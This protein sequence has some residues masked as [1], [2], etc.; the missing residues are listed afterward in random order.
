[1]REWRN[2]DKAGN[3]YRTADRSDRRY[4]P[5]G[6]LL[7]SGGTHYRHD[8]DGNLVEK[9]APDGRLWRY[10]WDGAGYL[11]SL[12]LPDGKH[13]ENIYDGLGRRVTKKV[14]DGQGTTLRELRF[15]WD[16]DTVAHEI[17]SDE[18]PSAW[19]FEP[20][21]FAPLAKL[22]GERSFAAVTDHLGTPE[23]F[24]DQAGVPAWKA[25]LDLYGVCR[26]EVETTKQPWRWPGQYEDEETGLFYNRFRW[27][28]PED[29]R[30]VSCDPIG[31]DGGIQPY[32]YVP[33][34]FCVAD[35]YGL[36]WNYRLV[37]NGRPYYVGHASDATT[38]A[39]VIS[40]HAATPRGAPASGRRFVRG[41]DVFE[42]ITPV[43]TGRSVA[44]GIEE[45]GMRD[46]GTFIGPRHV[47]G[48][49]APRVRG[50]NIRGIRPDNDNLE[51][52]LADARTWL[53]QRGATSVRDL[54]DLLRPPTTTP[55]C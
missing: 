19:V 23:A 18:E 38:P 46:H 14:K 11:Q 2:P 4:G 47:P 34:P 15:V 28:D 44:R 35:P 54:P 5:G 36:D 39:Q 7:E 48:D 32:G 41:E 42:Q 52:Y 9:R 51:T 37:R 43:G 53:Q 12:E 17:S 8:E 6:V 10:A 49:P 40:R 33:D 31:L 29:G 45:L 1:M 24:Y 3:L 21:H 25:Q 55:D 13:V 16:G 22:Q 20:G 27:Y 50:N 30:Y 26:A